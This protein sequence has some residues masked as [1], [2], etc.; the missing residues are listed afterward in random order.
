MFA[1]DETMEKNRELYH[2]SFRIWIISISLC[3]ITGCITGY[4]LNDLN[5]DILV[6]L[7]AGIVFLPILVVGS[8]GLKSGYSIGHWWNHIYKRRKAQLTN[9][10]FIICYICL[11][12]FVFARGN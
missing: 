4:G 5:P 11:M 12:L 8:Y 1:L 7:V 2:H 10:L 6:P 9:A 3:V